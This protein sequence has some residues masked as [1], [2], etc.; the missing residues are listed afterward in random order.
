MDFLATKV[1]LHVNTKLCG[2]L[3]N[4]QYYTLKNLNRNNVSHCFM[5]IKCG[6]FMLQ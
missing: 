2:Y 6:Q 1:N 4:H 5:C 3:P